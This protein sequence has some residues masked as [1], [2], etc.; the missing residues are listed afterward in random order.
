VAPKELPESVA[1]EAAA[2]ADDE[3][4]VGFQEAAARYLA[5]TRTGSR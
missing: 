2:I 4:R 5:M 3:I 1:A